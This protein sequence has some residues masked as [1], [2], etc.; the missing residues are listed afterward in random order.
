MLHPNDGASTLHPI[1]TVPLS[2]N[3]ARGFVLHF[4]IIQS[5]YDIFFSKSA[6][7]APPVARDTTLLYA[8]DGDDTIDDIADDE[9]DH[10]KETDLADTADPSELPVMGSSTTSKAKKGKRR[11]A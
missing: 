10:E 7:F 1:Q 5:A 6:T 4:G 3:P 9:D 11:A 2:L 8:T